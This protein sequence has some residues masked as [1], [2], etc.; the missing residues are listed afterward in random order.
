MTDLTKQELLDVIQYGCVWHV[1]RIKD[2]LEKVIAGSQLDYLEISWDDDDGGFF[3]VY[4]NECN[5]FVE[6]GAIDL[7]C[8]RDSCPNPYKNI[9]HPIKS[10][11]D[12]ED[13]FNTFVDM[14]LE[15]QS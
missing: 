3:Y 5:L 2:E 7:R 11:K 4:D 10:L 12:L 9:N 13:C 15:D 8:D 14:V 1:K 6:N